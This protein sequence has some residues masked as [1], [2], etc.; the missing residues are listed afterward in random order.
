[1]SGLLVLPALLVGFTLA[2]PHGTPGA[3]GA[4]GTSGELG[5]RGASAAPP[6]TTKASTKAAIKAATTNS[7]SLISRRGVTE[8][9]EQRLA[10]D[11]SA[12]AALQA[13]TSPAVIE[14]PIDASNSLTLHLE[15][16]EVMAPDAEFIAM[17]DGKAQRLAAPDVQL[18]RGSVVGERD[19]HAFLALRAAGGHE[20]NGGD[21]WDATGGATG[22][23]SITLADGRSFH[24]AG[25]LVDGKPDGL[26]VRSGP[27]VLPEFDEFC[28][29]LD[30]GHLADDGGIA[31]AP[32]ID[33][34]RG[35]R[36]V[37]V[38]IDSDASYSNLFNDDDEA[39]LAYIVQLV[40]AVSDIYIR[41][42]N[43]KLALEFSRIWPDGGEPFSA[44]D[45]YGFRKYWQANEDTTGLN[46]VHM[47]SARRN[48]S[49]GGIA[50]LSDACSGDAYA[51]SGF[52]LGAF[53]SP[54]EQPHLGNWDI[55]VV[56]HEMGHNLGTPHTHD[57]EPPVDTC[58]FGTNE[59]GTIM[60]Y[61][62]IRPGGL[63]NIDP[64][65]HAITE[66]IINADNPAGV[67]LFHDCNANGISDTLDIAIDA[68]V[69]VDANGV[70]DECDDCN[71]NG[72]LDSLDI[73]AGEP[74]VNA[75]SIPDSC[76]GDCN[77]N[78]IPDRWEIAQ[79]SAADLN[80]NSVPDACEPDCDG[81]GVA[82]F[83]DIHVGT[84]TDLDRD[85]VPDIC[86]D[87]NGNGLADWIDVDRQFNVFIGL[88]GGAVREYHAASGVIVQEHGAGMIQ[89]AFDLAFGP[90]GALY[91]A[92]FFTN[93]VI[94]VDV[95]SGQASV[96]IGAGVL[97][98]SALA[99]GHDGNLYVANQSSASVLKFNGTTGAPM[100]VFVAPGAGGLIS[101][102]DLAFGP[103]G[104]LYITSAAN[105]VLRY[106]GGSG[107]FA[108]VFISDNLIGPRGILFLPGGD[109]LI[110]NYA[111]GDVL[112]FDASGRPVDVFND[113]YPVVLPWGLAQG[114]GGNVFFARSDNSRVIE[115]D[116]ATGIY[117][118]S[119]I[120]GDELLVNPAQLVF[121]PASAND[122]DGDSLPDECDEP[123]C[124]ADIAPPDGGND[125]VGAADLGALLAAWGACPAEGACPADI[126]PPGTPGDGDGEVNAADLAQLLA[127]WGSCP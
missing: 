38:A 112:R 115:Y 47:F 77:A 100:G 75:N 56:A 26:V 104:D 4:S 23:G 48:L 69:D 59:R 93:Q 55:V 46:L 122:I 89:G 31:G 98:P 96:F 13:S 42:L 45:V 43:L 120:R 109:V 94:R 61:C 62:H 27:P 14:L 119:F 124:P 108:N 33:P 52:L 63:L 67:C 3:H 25:D 91:V 78:S 90:D 76:E 123:Q 60:S 7:M 50:F 41:D 24:L 84:F 102:W 64:R 83:L 85:S 18:F 2:G 29:L 15:R 116:D 107:A 1:M 125:E 9:G 51:I 58:A 37:T 73:L 99:F 95:D 105:L 65:M 92:S 101:P 21:A 80:G 20:G 72:T 57:Y 53:P 28:V 81:N 22:G 8:R 70:P 5:A 103:D 66:Q 117:Q 86:Q 35:P 114:P 127:N 110:A 39:A 30:D 19:S 49:Y 68:S 82:D 44:D 71:A 113:E 10:I 36:V 40:G 97:A 79:Q 111:G 88:S 6:M 12:L 74:D 126:A 106:D 17:R 118:R 34:A 32:G 87:C 11:L 16:F 54:V 121:R